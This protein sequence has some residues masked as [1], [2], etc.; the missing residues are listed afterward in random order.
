MEQKGLSNLLS[1]VD[2]GGKVVS[3]GRST[4]LFMGNL[5][6][7]DNNKE[8]NETKEEFNLPVS[9]IGSRLSN[10]GLDVTG[11]LLRVKLRADHPITRG[12]PEYTGVFHRGNPV[13]TTSFPNFDMDRRIIATFPGENV[14]LSGYI[15]N[16][17]LLKDQ[18]ALVWVRKGDGQIILFSFSP[19]FRGSTPATYKLLFN[20]ILPE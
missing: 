19:L 12:M 15:E 8:D 18:A 5:S 13:F 7:S 9:N 17:K 3:W 4:D 1:F 14:L 20:S 6:I 16:E 11:S 10:Q 2:K